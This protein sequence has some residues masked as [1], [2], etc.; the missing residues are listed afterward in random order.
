VTHHGKSTDWFA[1]EVDTRM[2]PGVRTVKVKALAETEAAL[3]EYAQRRQEMNQD[4]QQQAREAVVDLML[5]ERSRL[6]WEL[7]AERAPTSPG[8]GRSMSDVH[9]RPIGDLIEHDAEDCTCGP[10]VEPVQREDGSTGWLY[11]HHSLDG[12]EAAE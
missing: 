3:K 4:G 8:G 7:E 11:I 2:S 10:T 12:R 5:D 6:I 9:V 1:D